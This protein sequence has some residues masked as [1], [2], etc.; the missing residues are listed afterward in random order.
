MCRCRAL[1]VAITFLIGAISCRGTEGE[2]TLVNQ[3]G[4]AITGRELEV[5]GQRFNIRSM[6]P[7]E[8][9]IINFKVTKDSDYKVR[10]TMESGSELVRTVG[11][12]THGFDFKDE[13]WV[14][15]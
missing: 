15:S 11:Y 13:L 7:G 10:L 4:R 3:S 1:C 6:K 8:R 5:S 14:D 9:Q 12:V 2:V